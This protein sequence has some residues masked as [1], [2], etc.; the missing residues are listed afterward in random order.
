[1]ISE[2]VK[3]TD[4]YIEKKIICPIC[5][6]ELQIKFRGYVKISK[7]NKIYKSNKITYVS[8]YWYKC[9]TENRLVF[10]ETIV[11]IPE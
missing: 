6:N 11:V 8:G 9:N 3:A 5:H 4:D 2:Q 1:M 10:I 7:L